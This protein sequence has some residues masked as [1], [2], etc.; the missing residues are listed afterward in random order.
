MGQ[1]SRTRYRLACSQYQDC[2]NSLPCFVPANS[3]SI[4]KNPVFMRVSQTDILLGN[5]FPAAFPEAGKL[6]FWNF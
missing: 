6:H 5:L 4:F 3:L 1:E 2:G